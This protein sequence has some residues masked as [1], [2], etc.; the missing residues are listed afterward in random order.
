MIDEPVHL[1]L[2]SQGELA[3]HIGLEVKN[4]GDVELVE[5]LVAV[6]REH[7]TRDGNLGIITDVDVAQYGCGGSV[8]GEGV[9]HP[10]AVL[11][12]ACKGAAYARS[13]PDVEPLGL[14]VGPELHEV[15]L[16][17]YLHVVRVHQ[18]VAVGLGRRHLIVKLRESLLAAVA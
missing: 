14:A 18:V 12:A 6:G 7:I 13:H 9:A 1:A 17:T 11:V 5:L 15:E 16:G 3:A 8:L 4:G 10:H 2:Q